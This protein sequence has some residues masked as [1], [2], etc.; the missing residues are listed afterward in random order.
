MS[1]I[2]KV[3]PNFTQLA[4][5]QLVYYDEVTGNFTWLN[6]KRTTVTG[7]LAGWKNSNNYLMITVF[8]Q[9]LKQHRLA[10]FY[11]LGKMP[12][13]QLDHING[14]KSDNSWKNIREATASENSL[15]T[16]IKANNTS[17]YR[18]VSYDKTRKL[19]K[20]KGTLNKVEVYLGRFY[21]KEEA[22]NAYDTWA[23]LTHKEFYFENTPA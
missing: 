7:K 5:K 23:K 22:K 13:K 10:Y 9:T 12:E 4:L 1:K 18:G 19:W 11:K 3:V 6:P 17:G 15:N 21:L 14:N 20:A 8:G 16:Q 2:T